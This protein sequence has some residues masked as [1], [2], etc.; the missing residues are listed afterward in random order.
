MRKIVG[1]LTR[2]LLSL[3]AVKQPGPR[4]AKQIALDTQ[5]TERFVKGMHRNTPSTGR[6]NISRHSWPVS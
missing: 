6:D 2:K 4:A 5:R 1:C 3:N